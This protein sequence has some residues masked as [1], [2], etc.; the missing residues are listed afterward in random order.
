MIKH[1]LKIIWNQR[2]S[3]GWIFAELLVVASVLWVMVDMF[4]VDYKTY[5]APLG[6]DI[7]NVWRF[8]LSQLG[9]LAPGYVPDSLYRSSDPED[10]DRLMEQIRQNPEVEEVCATFYSTP[11]L[12]GD[13][14]RDIVPLDGDT[15]VSSQM[16]FQLRNVTPEFFRLFRVKTPDGKPVSDQIAGVHHA[17]VISKEMADIFYHGENAVGRKVIYSGQGDSYRI[18]AVSSS[19]RRYEYDRA[20]PCFFQ[21][22][23]GDIFNRIVEGFGARNAHVCVRMKKAYTQE[24]MNGW[25]ETMGDRLTVNN[26]YVYGVRSLADFREKVLRFNDRENKNKIALM[27]FMLVN[28]FFGIIGTFWVRMQNRRGEIGLRKALGANRITL[29]KYMYIEGL[30]LLLLTLPLVIVLTGNLAFTGYL[31]TYRVPL[32]A[33][34]LLITFGFTYLLMGSMICFGIWFP[35]RQSVRM[36]PADALHY[37]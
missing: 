1:I 4:W 15:T 2:R 29:Q 18:A 17:L 22:M 10:L 5:H 31:D 20:E 12:N 7:T 11:Y 9:E 24:E 32:S 35:I 3:N 34:R 33:E 27:S 37:E 19:F 30:S 21:C 14:W 26:L 25:L 28:V 36:A 23:D 6:F 13:S 16:S 8:K